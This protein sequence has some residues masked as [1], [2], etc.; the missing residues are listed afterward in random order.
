MTVFRARPLVLALVRLSGPRLWRGLRS[1]TFAIC[2]LTV[3][4]I[5]VVAGSF[6][7]QDSG[8]RLVYQS[9]WFYGLNVILMASVLSCVSRR[10]M[11]VFRF[12][13]RPPVL[14]RAEFYRAGDTAR[15]HATAL[16]PERAAREVA[17]ALRSCH[18]RVEMKE[19]DGRYYLLAD[20]FRLM[21]LGTLIS[22]FSIVLMVA[23]IA[24]GALAGWLDKAVMLE[25]G[26]DPV[27]IGH[28]TG[29]QLRSDAFNFGLYPDGLPRN[30]HDHLTVRAP[31]G[32]EQH[33]M[34]DVNTPWYYGGVFGYDIHQDSYAVNARLIAIDPRDP[35]PAPLGYCAI[36]DNAED[37]KTP[38]APLLLA[39]QGD[40]SYQPIGTGLS[41]FY[42]PQRNLA[43]SFSFHDAVPDSKLPATATITVAQPPR[44]A[45]STMRILREAADIPVSPHEFSGRVELVTATPVDVGGLRFALL[46][47]RVTFLNI[48]HNPAV[49]FIFATFVLILIGLVAVLY[50]PFSRLWLYVAPGDQDG[51]SVVAMR[52]MAE[53]SKQGF[54]RR[55]ERIAAAVERRLDPAVAAGQAEGLHV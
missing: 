6:L 1:M 10:A 7:P 45:G 20:R 18:Y 4:L 23:T 50:F 55:M 9:W 3:I 30:F 24:W 53:K 28:G 5:T 34:I 27:A 51:G 14:H 35:H 33:Q 22:H 12:S 44:G 49:P 31:D 25:A 11:P 42:L 32:S 21:R 19:R 43:I 47:R 39:P 17:R 54:K 2:M 37:C 41:A 29:L 26:G 8:V 48:G 40:G 52:G 38:F 36:T 16:P 46:I 13:F 15:S